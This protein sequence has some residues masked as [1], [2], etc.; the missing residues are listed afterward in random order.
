MT[1][2]W[3]SLKEAPSPPCLRVQRQAVA[4]RREL[5]G[6]VH[7]VLVLRSGAFADVVGNNRIDF[8]T[9]AAK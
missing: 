1:S 8:A 5:S 4:E 3:R 2:E 7:R 6:T 9:T